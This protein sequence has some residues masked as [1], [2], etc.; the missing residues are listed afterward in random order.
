MFHDIY[1]LNYWNI[2]N[3]NWYTN[4]YHGIDLNICF[5]Y[6]TFLS[7]SC[8]QVD[9]NNRLY[10][11]HLILVL[12]LSG[13]I[14]HSHSFFSF[15]SRSHFQTYF[16]SLSHKGQIWYVLQLAY[17]CDFYKLVASGYRAEEWIQNPMT[18]RSLTFCDLWNSF[19]RWNWTFSVWVQ[20]LNLC[21]LS[22]SHS[23]LNKQNTLRKLLGEHFKTK[24][25]SNG[26]PT[27]VHWSS[28]APECF[29]AMPIDNM[30]IC[31]FI[32]SLRHFK[33]SCVLP[34]STALPQLEWSLKT[35]LLCWE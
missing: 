4:T 35:D 28:I 1:L 34:L 16:Y 27:T 15:F 5:S 6:K 25:S 10:Q 17:P 19:W 2:L 7:Y 8:Y 11:N 13:V 30:S 33:A 18:L 31:T 32:R 21:P 23:P 24:N 12:Q 26:C 29:Q 3:K 22:C 14:S 20:L 9:I